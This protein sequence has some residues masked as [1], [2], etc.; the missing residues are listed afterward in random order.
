MTISQL[1]LKSF[2]SFTDTEFD[3]SAPRVLIAGLNG[4]GK[5]T[6][7]EAVKWALT[8]RCQGLDGKGSGAE[9]L[10]PTFAPSLHTVD[11]ALTLNNTVGVHRVWE[12]RGATLEVDGFMGTPT[13]QQKALYSELLDRESYV[14]AVL[15]SAVFLNLHHADA[16]ALVL[17]LLDVRV[18][19][20]GKEY[21]L[22]QLDAAHDKA[23]KDRKS[24]KDKVKGA[25]VPAKPESPEPALKGKTLADAEAHLGGIAA[26]LSSVRKAAAELNQKI[27]G[28]V[29]QRRD[30]TARL[31]RLTAPRP[32]GGD[33]DGIVARI[34]EVEE[35]LAIIEEDATTAPAVAQRPVENVDLEA[36]KKQAQALRT[37]D[38]KNGC[39]LDAR[40]PCP[41]AKVKFFSRARDIEDALEKL[42]P[43][44]TPV[45]EAQPPNPL[46]NELSD[47]QRQKAAH[48]AYT[49][50]MTAYNANRAELT[51]E[52]A[53][54]PDHGALEVELEGLNARILK[55]E[56]VEKTAIAFFAG[57][58]VHE[59][60]L[61]HRATLEAEVARLE[62]LVALLGPNGARV[63]AL[64]DA[65]GPF[66]GEINAI[67]APFDWTVGFQ[68]DPWT[69]TVNGR[70]VDTYSRSEQHRIGIALQVAIA[71]MSG[72][73]FAIVDELDMLDS[74]NRELMGRVL[75]ASGLEQVILLSTRELSQPMPDAANIPGM[76]CIRLGKENGRT[77]VLEQSRQVVAA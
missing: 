75:Y 39:V 33:Y 58:K 30:L 15:D 63:Q 10:V 43:M 55:G 20:E 27:G 13:E 68:V 50:A 66:E 12:P 54:V 35:R 65:L 22:A 46:V 44:P 61:Q 23:F 41:V 5:S 37:F 56:A 3:L 62:T 76:A 25:F 31:D 24:A 28:S 52:L 47:L 21:T 45:V 4:A 40:T 57:L 1:N 64:A 36:R 7:R 11:V 67:L 59:D 16:K 72:L 60:G 8:G 29:S 9:K 6:I 38:P 19:V 71:E 51:A 42:A 70:P 32:I 34:A 49:S 18:T 69:V 17:D 74:E 14:D 48:E 2:R 26:L 77:V 73:G 53:A